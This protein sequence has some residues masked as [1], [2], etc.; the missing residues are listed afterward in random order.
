MPYEALRCTELYRYIQMYRLSVMSHISFKSLIYILFFMPY[1][2]GTLFVLTPLFPG[3]LHFMP[4]GL[5][6]QV[7]G[8]SRR[9]SALR[10]VLLHCTYSGVAL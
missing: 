3:G 10:P 5:E 8:S 9:I 2:L 7:D 6:I 4:A 1:I